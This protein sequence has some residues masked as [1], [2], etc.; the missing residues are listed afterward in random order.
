MS[1]LCIVVRFPSTQVPGWL[2]T[3]LP[4]PSSPS[5]F[6]F[7]QW[8]PISNTC[9]LTTTLRYW[10]HIV[11]Y[12]TKNLKNLVLS[13]AYTKIFLIP[14]KSKWAMVR[15]SLPIGPLMTRG[16]KGLY[17]IATVRRLYWL[18]LCTE[19]RFW[20]NADMTLFKP[21][22]LKKSPI[23][24]PDIWQQALVYKGLLEYS[25]KFSKNF[26]P[27]KKQRPKNDSEKMF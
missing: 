16:G 18:Y 21:N 10:L 5:P 23:T 26:S 19:E 9:P 12:R 7:P 13:Y 15:R 3:D 6:P 4:L 11:R 27:P 24:P 14:L 25:F 2:Y 1:L 8:F 20:E 22:N 17:C